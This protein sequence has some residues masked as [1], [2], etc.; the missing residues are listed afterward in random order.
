MC[1]WFQMKTAVLLL[2]YC[3]RILLTT[4][5]YKILR[6]FKLD[7]NR[8]NG[9]YKTRWKRKRFNALEKHYVY[10]MITVNLHMNGTN[11]TT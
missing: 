4:T 2:R 10:E 1:I 8:H 6:K 9:H 5:E 7:H 11:I 3:I